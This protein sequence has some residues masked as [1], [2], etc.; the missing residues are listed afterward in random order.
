MAKSLH[1]PLI[2]RLPSGPEGFH[3][4]WREAPARPFDTLREGSAR[5]YRRLYWGP[6]LAD[7]FWNALVWLKNSVGLQNCY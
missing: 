6:K 7:Y 2:Q 4:T 5:D 3:P 1:Q